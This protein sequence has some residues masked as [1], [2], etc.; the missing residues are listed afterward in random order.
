MLLYTPH[1]CGLGAEL[2]WLT[3]ALQIALVTRRQLVIREDVPW[4]YAEAPFCAPGEGTF[5]CYF[6]PLS[7][8]AVRSDADLAALLGDSVASLRKVP[9]I[10]SADLAAHADVR[11]VQ[12]TT[13]LQQQ[14]DFKFTRTVP[15]EWHERLL[16]FS[17][18][19][20]DLFWWRSQLV[21]YIWRF[22]PR[23]DALLAQ[24]RRDA[25]PEAALAAGAALIGVHSRSGDK[26]FGSGLQPAEMRE[27]DAA[28]KVAMIE[29]VATR[30][31]ARVG[32][33][34]FAAAFVATKDP[35]TLAVL[36]AAVAS[37]AVPLVWD[38]SIHRYG[39]GFS[40]EDLV[41]G[42][43]NRT[44][45]ALDALSDVDILSRCAGKLFFFFFVHAPNQLF[46]HFIALTN[47]SVAKIPLCLC[48]R[49]LTAVSQCFWAR[50]SRICRGWWQRWRRSSSAPSC[51]R[52][53]SAPRRGGGH[54][55]K[56]QFLVS[57]RNSSNCMPFCCCC[58]GA[59]AA[60]LASAAIGTAVRR[61]SALAA[62]AGAAGLLPRP[63]SSEAGFAS[64]SKTELLAGCG[65]AVVVAAAATGRAGAG[66]D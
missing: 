24:R 57:D 63:R 55:R 3:V 58:C 21:G 45:E 11:V 20:S 33:E 29:A 7:A 41:K 15:P 17:S 10:T 47:Y 66:A 35:Q 13:N 37:S 54:F 52:L 65:A 28:W 25:L 31:A 49:S 56:V 64:K 62:A 60:G 22:T 23:V 8:C 44:Q 53:A 40:T 42:T 38:G 19:I 6:R 46:K 34:R 18:A 4:I 39:R 27:V 26:V 1:E 12:W 5:S 50:W 2:H 30:C 16:P 61:E 9:I 43:L 32:V 59:A 36:R 14:L 48:A 51:S